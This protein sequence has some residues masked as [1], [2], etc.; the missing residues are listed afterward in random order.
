MSAVETD[1]I[2]VLATRLFPDRETVTAA[3]ESLKPGTEIVRIDLEP[4]RMD[5]G[6]WDAVVREILA[7]DKVITL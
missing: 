5:R 4:E 2:V 3:V 7:A 6:Q 1:R